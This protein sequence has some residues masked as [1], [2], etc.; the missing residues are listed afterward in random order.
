MPV[1]AKV[2]GP[3]TDTVLRTGNKVTIPEQKEQERPE[4]DPR[5]PLY[6]ITNSPSSEIGLQSAAQDFKKM[7]EPKTTILKGGYLTNATLIFNSWLK[8]IE[9]C[10]LERNLSNGKAVQLVKDFT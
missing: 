5:T 4:V 9:M 10:V 6:P 8:D 2:L 7:R 1:G 3:S